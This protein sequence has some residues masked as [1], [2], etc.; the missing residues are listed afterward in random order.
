MLC[1][2]LLCAPSLIASEAEDAV[3]AA[4]NHVLL[5][6]GD[7]WKIASKVYTARRTGQ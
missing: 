1:V 6:V 4:L 7:E 5:K 3:R 2:V